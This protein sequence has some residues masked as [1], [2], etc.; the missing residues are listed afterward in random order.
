VIVVVRTVVFMTPPCVVVILGEARDDVF[1]SSVS[2]TVVFTDDRT[3]AL[4]TPTSVV[5]VFTDGQ[6]QMY[7][8]LG[9]PVPRG[10]QCM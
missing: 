2:F 9:V 8:S 6:T 3:V 4:M 7:V 10:T 1:L 5:V